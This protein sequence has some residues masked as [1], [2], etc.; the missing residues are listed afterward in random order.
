MPNG[1]AV[2][3][4]C[5]QATGCSDRPNPVRRYVSGD[6]PISGKARDLLTLPDSANA[7]ISAPVPACQATKAVPPFGSISMSCDTASMRARCVKACGKF[8]RCSP[9]VVSI[10]SA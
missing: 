6:R 10:S 4:P 5:G 2:T 9:A 8:P 3:V 1:T 7:L